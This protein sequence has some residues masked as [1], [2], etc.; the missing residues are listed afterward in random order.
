M[1]CH[2]LIVGLAGTMPSEREAAL[3]RELVPFGFILFRRNCDNPAQVRALVAA[4]KALVPHDPPIL[5]DQEGG[6]VS[7]LSQPRWPRFPAPGALDLIAEAGIGSR[8]EAAFWHARLIGEVLRN[9]DITVD[10]APVLDI[11]VPDSE[12]MVLG[13]RTYGDT[14]EQVEL[15]GLHAVRGLRE[16]GIVPVIKHLPG[17]GRARVDSHQSLPRIDASADLLRDTDFRPFRTIAGLY[18][19]RVMGMTGHLLLSAFDTEQP[20]SLSPRLIDEVIRQEIGFVGHLMADDITMGAL[21]GSLAERAAG[22]IVAGCDSVL[23]CAPDPEPWP[24]LAAAVGEISPHGWQSWL[25]ASQARSSAD[26]PMNAEDFLSQHRR[27]LTPALVA[28]SNS[29]RMVDPTGG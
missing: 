24:Q 22:A 7:R 3:I 15:C 25:G 8:E 12:A 20:V 2:A 19:D 17:H 6:R 13:D 26:T 14:A 1:S 29:A 21:S 16:A 11:P 28:V 18:G 4:L 5:I 27:W 23:Y 9:L 10:C